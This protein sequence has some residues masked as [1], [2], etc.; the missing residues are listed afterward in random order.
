MSARSMRLCRVGPPVVAAA[1]VDP[2]HKHLDAQ[3]P[4][5]A[6]ARVDHVGVAP[7]V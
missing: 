7:G 2:V 3:R 4:V 5:E 6:G 1:Q